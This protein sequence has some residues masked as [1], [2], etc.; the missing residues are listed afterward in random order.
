MVKNWPAMWFCLVWFLSQK[1]PLEKGMAAHSSI[2]AWRIPWIE[3]PGDL[4]SMGLQRVRHNWAT[5]LT[6]TRTYPLM[7]KDK[8]LWKLPDG[9]NWLR[10]KLGLVL[11][12]RAMPSKY[13]IQFSA[14]RKNI[15]N[16]R[17]AD[18]TTLMAESKEELKSLFFFFPDKFLFI[19]FY[20]FIFFIF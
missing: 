8:G 2:L 16:L 5:T 13:L 4:Q 14:A 17:Y 12:G 19:Y 11:T 20:Y 18:E 6:L 1:D 10:G 3:K 7:E 9:R 15:S